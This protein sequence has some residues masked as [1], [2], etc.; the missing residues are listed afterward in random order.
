MPRP[1]KIE[2]VAELKKRVGQ[3]SALYFLDFA[4]VGANDFNMLRRRLQEAGASVRV[5][6]NRLLLRALSESGVSSDVTDLLRG[7]T[8]L[9]FATGDPVAPARVIREVAKRLDGLKVKG[10]YMD[11]EVYS[12]ER[13][14]FLATL[15]TE[16]ELRGQL[17]GVL[18]APITELAVDL[19]GLLSELVYVL[20][21]LRERGAESSAA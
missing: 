8:S 2:A 18:A 14:V 6:K 10:A 16:G 13:F 7:P 5:V 17:V 19:E 4:K 3:A 20:D 12:S 9:V 1:E 15:P 21:Q 11:D